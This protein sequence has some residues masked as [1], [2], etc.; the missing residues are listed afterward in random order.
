MQHTAFKA[1]SYFVCQMFIL[2]GFRN[3]SVLKQRILCLN[4]QGGGMSTVKLSATAYSAYVRVY[5]NYI[6][7]DFRI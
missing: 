7:E 2:L 5:L 4:L 3:R 6:S 1:I